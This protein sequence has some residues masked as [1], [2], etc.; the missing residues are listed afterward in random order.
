MTCL[1]RGTSCRPRNCPRVL[2]ESSCFLI[3]FSTKLWRIAMAWVTEFGS[4]SL[5]TVQQTWC[6]SVC[7]GRAAHLEHESHHLPRASADGAVPHQHIEGGNCGGRGEQALLSIHAPALRRA[8]KQRCATEG[9][10]CLESPPRPSRPLRSTSVLA[11]LVPR[12]VCRRTSPSQAP[13]CPRLTFTSRRVSPAISAA[14]AAPKSPCAS[15]S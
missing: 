7:A 11:R 8:L 2:S 13:R 12:P 1:R 3:T 15:F 9:A 10:R 6:M 5:C 4:L 14:G